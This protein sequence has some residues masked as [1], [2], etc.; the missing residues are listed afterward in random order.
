METGKLSFAQDL[1]AKFP[2][3]LHDRPKH[4]VV[5]SPSKENLARI[6]LKEC[7]TN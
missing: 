6:E 7:A 5:A 3:T 4:L 1:V 2:T